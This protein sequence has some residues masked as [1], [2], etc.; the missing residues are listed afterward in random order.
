MWVP[1]AL[2]SVTYPASHLTPEVGEC[3]NSHRPQFTCFQPLPFPRGTKL[4]YCIAVL[5]FS[6]SAL[7]L[8]TSGIFGFQTKG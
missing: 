8:S 1:G 2:D 7:E 3:I 6:P 4:T 5:S